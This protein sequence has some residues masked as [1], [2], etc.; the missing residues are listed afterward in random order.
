M[1]RAN[2]FAE[3][4]LFGDSISWSSRAPY[5]KRYADFIERGLQKGL[6]DDWVVD[7]AA[8]GDGGNTAE[9]GLARIERD[10]IAY[11]PTVVVINFGGND[12]GRAPSRESFMAAL[13]AIV[14]TIG[15]KTRAA[16]VLETIPGV[17]LERHAWRDRDDIM[18]AGGQEVHLERF[19]NTFIRDLSERGGIPLH[20]RFERFHEMLKH[21]GSAW[22]TLIRPDGVHLTVA[23]N[24]CFGKTLAEMVL[25]IVA[26]LGIEEESKETGAVWL[27]RAMENPVYRACCDL[28]ERGGLEEYFKDSSVPHRLLLQQTRSFSRRAGASMVEPALRREA[29]VVERIASGLLAVKRTMNGNVD[30]EAIEATVRL[31]EVELEPARSDPIIRRILERIRTS[32]R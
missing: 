4:V 30:A 15:Q 22:D 12:A 21:D 32:D 29:L 19:A 9:E 8:C 20:D 13:E 25:G 23:G 18:E 1:E 27:E 7:V 6:G 26:E 17:H 10:V 2:R 31:A 3:V 5:G 11:A 16:V 28:L 24:E 14:D